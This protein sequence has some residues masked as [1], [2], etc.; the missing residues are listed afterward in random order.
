MKKLVKDLELM[1]YVDGNL[2]ANERLS[3][4]TRMAQNGE[5][6]LLMLLH[7]LYYQSNKGLADELLGKDDFAIGI[8]QDDLADWDSGQFLSEVLRNPSICAQAACKN[9][10]DE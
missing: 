2:S 6:D 5:L 10:K 7:I 9:L 3:V 4:K 8:G 1:A